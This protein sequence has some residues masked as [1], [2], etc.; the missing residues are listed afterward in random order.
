MARMFGQFA[1]FIAYWLHL[2]A[3]AAWTGGLLFYLAV[4]RPTLGNIAPAE[5]KK[6]M[7]I[8]GVRFRALGL[9][10]LGALLLTGLIL[11]N[12]ILHS[13]DDRAEFLESGYGRMLGIKIA[14]SLLVVLISSWVALGPVP[15]MVAALESRDETQARARGRLILYM[16]VLVLILSVL[17]GFLVALMRLSA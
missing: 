1:E 13:V 8:A 16:G 9:L 3:A 7:E 14:V 10:L 17:V 15:G 12:S 4:L 2:L 5:A 11:T 6:F